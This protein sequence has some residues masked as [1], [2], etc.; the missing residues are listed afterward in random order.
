MSVELLEYRGRTMPAPKF[1]TARDL[2]APTR[3]ARQRI[4]ADVWL[5]QP[6]MPWQ[7]LVADVL[8]ELRPDGLPR[9]PL[10]VVTLPRQAGKS[11]L[12]MARAGERCLSCAGYR[13][14]YTAQ[15]GGDAQDQ[16]LKFQ[17]EIVTGRPLDAVVTTLRGNGHAV[18]R[19]P[20]TSTIRPHPPTEAALHGK[21]SDAND[22][23]EGWAFTDEQG[24]AIMQA[25]AP[26]QLTRPGAQTVI[27]SAGGTAASTWLAGLVARGRAGD[28]S[29]AF[30]EWG[31]PDDLPLDDL[32][33]IAAHHPA[34]GHTITVD[35]LATLRAQLD[36][37]SEFARAAGNRWTEVIGG[38]LPAELY[39][40]TT[41]EIPAGVP[42]AY[43]AARSP[44]GDQ[45]A[46]V[47]AARVDGRLVLEVL[48]VLN[49]GH[50]AAD[51]LASWATDG[52]I[53]TPTVGATRPLNDALHRLER[54]PQLVDL[55]GG[56]EAAACANLLDALRAGAATFRQHPDLDDAVRVAGRRKVGAGGWVWSQTVAGTPIATLEAAT[57]AAWA[58]DRRP[59]EIAAPVVRFGGAA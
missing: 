14:W 33:A 45:V 55:A 31:I 5:G 7:E 52:P 6:F 9:Y 1:H 20:N 29:L 58:L 27:W 8:G 38:A 51:R 28:P 2:E 17:D 44:A 56:D 32:E 37:D 22:I 40:L 46:L 49:R 16:F 48:E 39:R 18:M 59:R 23:D 11:H 41:D 3:G 26:T 42:V 53:G 4:F 21:Q 57:W 34:V 15:T 54:G 43:G 25:V 10:A 13:A 24:K 12:C 47:A 36:D 30:F 35:S 19:F 50:G